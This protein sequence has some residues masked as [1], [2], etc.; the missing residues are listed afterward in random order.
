MDTATLG[1]VYT[2]RKTLEDPYEDLKKARLVKA[3]IPSTFVLVCADL[4]YSPRPFP[5]HRD[6]LERHDYPAWLKWQQERDAQDQASTSPLATL[7]GKD[8]GKELTKTLP[9]KGRRS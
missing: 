2:L 5:G 4:K 7:K 8:L 3:A 6:F 1:H 9:K